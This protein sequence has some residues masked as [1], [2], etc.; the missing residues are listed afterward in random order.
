MLLLW[1]AYL[2]LLHFYGEGCSSKYGI[3]LGLGVSSFTFITQKTVLQTLRYQHVPKRQPRSGTSTWPL[4]TDPC[5]CKATYPP[6]PQSCSTVQDPGD[7][8][9][10]SHQAVPTPESPV[11]SLHCAHVLPFLFLF[12][13]STTYLLYLV[14]PWSLSVWGY[15]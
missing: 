6:P 13:V 12:Q 9:G 3:R 1:L 15:L 8:T 14:A 2:Q 11:L 4:V 10:R 7:V 5:C